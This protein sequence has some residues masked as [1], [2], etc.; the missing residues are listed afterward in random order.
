[1]A[2]QLAKLG[3]YT[4]KTWGENV[5]LQGAGNF[6][7]GFGQT[8]SRGEDITGIDTKDTNTNSTLLPLTPSG[9]IDVVND[10]DWNANQVL[11]AYPKMPKMYLYEREQVE[12]SLVSSY[13]YY[14]TQLINSVGNASSVSVTG[15][16]EDEY[17]NSQV[18]QILTKVSGFVSK[19]ASSVLQVGGLAQGN[20]AYRSVRDFVKFFYTAAREFRNLGAEDEALLGEYM[21]SYVGIYLTSPTGF[22]YIFPYFQNQFQ[23]AENNWG[24]TDKQPMLQGAVDYFAEEYLP[25]ITPGAYIEKPKYFN[26][27]QQ[28]GDSVTVSFPLLNTITEESYKKNYEFLWL[29]A[30]QNKYYR[31]SFASVRPPKIYTVQI[32]GVKYFPYA[33]ISNMTIDFVGTRRLLEVETPRG[34][35]EAPVPDAYQVEITLES[36][37]SDT[38]NALLSDNFHR[39]IN[40]SV[41]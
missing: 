27:Q 36:L 3:E 7:A 41:N 6:A 10:F 18:E 32:P 2:T 34:T 30:F 20:F 24:P 37:L 19:T 22:K 13:Y 38:A 25:F 31:E 21:K 29:L 4:R 35:V 12:S 14:I 9:V 15:T 33:Y 28:A 16:R 8:N 11:R 1:M 23:K 17:I 26:F 5:L 39:Q 40:V